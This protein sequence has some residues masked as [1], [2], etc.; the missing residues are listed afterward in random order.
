MF[1]IGGTPAIL[2]AFVRN[3]AHEPVGWGTQDGGVSYQ[4]ETTPYLSAA[5]FTAVKSS[6]HFQFHLPHS[7]ACSLV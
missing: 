2:V 1:V 4:G 3:D 5:V 7:S 6:N